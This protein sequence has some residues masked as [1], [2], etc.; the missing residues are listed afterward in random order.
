MLGSEQEKF[1]GKSLKTSKDKG[2]SW[3]L[4]ANQVIMAR[5]A[6]PDL[7]D[8][9]DEEFIKEIEKIFPQIYDYIALSPLGLP[10]NPESWDGYPV[11]R[12]RFYKLATDHGVNDLLVLTGDTHDYWANRLETVAGKAMGIELGVSGTTSPGT[13]AYFG[14]AGQDFSD[15]LTAKNKDIIYHGNQSHGYIDLTLTHESGQVDFVS[16]NTVYSPQ[17]KTAVSKSFKLE[18]NSDTISL[19]NI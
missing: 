14:A 2:Q 1:I 6:S 8:Y 17:Y 13:G 3:R 7:T 19:K 18:K 4:I 16:V 10:F 9:K 11:A 5:T 12:E 15:R